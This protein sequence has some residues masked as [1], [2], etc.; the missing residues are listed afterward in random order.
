MRTFYILVLFLFS[1]HLIN[2]QEICNNGIDDDG[3][4]DIDLLDSD[5]ECLSG[6]SNT[7]TIT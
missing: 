1:A 3:D 4:Q 5:C 7:L 2:A 6:G